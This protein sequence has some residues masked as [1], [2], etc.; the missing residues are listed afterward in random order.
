MID[1]SATLSKILT[2]FDGLSNADKLML[3]EYAVFKSL[4]SGSALL[5]QTDECRGLVAVIRGRMRASSVS[6]NGKEITLYRLIDGD[7][8]I[9]SASCLLKSIDFGISL[10]AEKDSEIFIIP[11][12]IYEKL[13]KY[14]IVKDFTLSELSGRFSDVFWVLNQFVFQGLEK[15]LAYTLIEHSHL[16]NSS[17]LALTH[18]QIARDL[19]TA[20]EVVSRLLKKFARAGFIKS[21]RGEIVILDRESLEKM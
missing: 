18:E 17:T 12:V 9:M 2:F 20:R 15:R 1:K 13:Q 14:D 10:C 21:S 5:S 16:F 7:C 19:G 11:T 8:C 4:K 3:S 6:S